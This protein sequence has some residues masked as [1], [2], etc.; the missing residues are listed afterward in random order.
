MMG[1]NKPQQQP[2]TFDDPTV[3]ANELNTFYARFDTYDTQSDCDRLCEPL[4]SSPVVLDEA[5]VVRCFKRINPH[6][7]PGPDGVCGRVLKVCA[8]QLGPVFTRLFQWF[9]DHHLMP[10][11]WKMSNIIPVPK[12]PSAK[13]MNDFRPVALTSVIAKCMERFF[14]CH[15]RMALKVQVKS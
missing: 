2:F 11:S 5:D 6:K 8:K 1:R 13:V 9:L 14:V 7:A 3:F 15:V 12:K 10:R 4:V